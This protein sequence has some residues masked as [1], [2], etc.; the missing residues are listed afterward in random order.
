MAHEVNIFGLALYM[1]TC[2]GS[3]IWSQGPGDLLDQ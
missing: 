2:T 1:D 3:F